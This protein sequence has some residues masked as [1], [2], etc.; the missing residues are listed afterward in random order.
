MGEEDKE[1]EDEEGAIKEP[2]PIQ[3]SNV[4]EEKQETEAHT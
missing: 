3:G 4:F 1:K 2:V